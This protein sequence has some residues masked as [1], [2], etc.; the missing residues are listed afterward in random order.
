MQLIVGH[1]SNWIIKLCGLLV[2]FKVLFCLICV[3]GCF[4]QWCHSYLLSFDIFRSESSSTQ[5]I[6]SSWIEM[7]KKEKLL[8][9][10][11][12]SDTTVLESSSFWCNMCLSPVPTISPPPPFGRSC[13]ALCLSLALF[14]MLSRSP[15]TPPVWH[16]FLPSLCNT[17]IHMEHQHT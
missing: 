6:S 1:S 7:G 9:A 2:F 5:I 10:T 4:P 16:S 12:P 15:P 17:T 13:S 14:H 8:S 11:G 3:E